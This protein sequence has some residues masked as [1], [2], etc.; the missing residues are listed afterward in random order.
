MR[1]LLL[2]AACVH[3]GTP[4]AVAQKVGDTVVVVADD[5]K[6]RVNGKFIHRIDRGEQLKIEQLDESWYLVTA[7][8]GQGYVHRGDAVLLDQ[9]IDYFTDAILQE[10]DA[11]NYVHRASVWSTMG[12]LDAAMRDFDEAVRLDPDSEYVYLARVQ[13]WHKRGNLDKAIADETE[14]IR[15][16]PTKSERHFGR[17]VSWEEKGE[18][19]LAIDDLNEAIRLNPEAT[20]Y[21]HYRAAV[22][23]EI[24]NFEMAI[25]DLTEMIRR[26]PKSSSG[27]AYR[28]EVHN[29]NGDF[30]NAITDF[31]EGMR[32]E[33][34][35]VVCPYQL[36]MLL[37]SCPDAKFRDGKRAV[38]LATKIC[39]KCKWEINPA[40]TTLAA[41][42]A[43]IG[44][45]ENAV[46]W[47]EKAA[48][49]ADDAKMKAEFHARLELYKFHRSY[50]RESKR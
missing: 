4:I 24:R 6:L 33:P 10:P 9:A 38:E 27:Y 22:Y 3:F 29:D 5:A 14:L 35:A 46:K 25:S 41:G 44:D 32:V 15:L 36:A 37:A 12:E 19:G 42:Y 20:R 48:D 50:R 43:E 18:Y 8:H 28:G 23:R 13:E 7:Y 2:A 39:E 34:D 31:N 21:I 49:L 11:F 26:K 45:F 30:G 17:A 1:A 16:N 40:M 47:Q